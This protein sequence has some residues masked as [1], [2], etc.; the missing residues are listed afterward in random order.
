MQPNTRGVYRD[1]QLE[2]RRKTAISTRW[3]LPGAGFFTLIEANTLRTRLEILWVNPGT[4]NVFLSRDLGQLQAAINGPFAAPQHWDVLEF[5]I[6]VVFPYVLDLELHGDI[7]QAKLF[8]YQSS[9]NLVYTTLETIDVSCP[10]LP[11]AK[12]VVIK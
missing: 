4:G 11:E 5:P 6:Q 12:A 9:P 1:A 2:G 8:G 7:V 10:C 3:F